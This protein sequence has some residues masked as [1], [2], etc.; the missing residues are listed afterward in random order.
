[1]KEFKHYML[2]EINEQPEVLS[3]ILDSKISLPEEL[4]K[5]CKKIYIVASGTSYHAGLSGKI[6]FERFLG[7]P[8]ETD[9]AS[10]F[11]LR[12]PL[13]DNESL[14]IF[15]SQSGQTADTLASLRYA[16]KIGAKTLALVNVMDSTIANEANFALDIKAGP[17]I[18]IASTKA[19]TA[20]LLIL[21][22][23][24]IEFAEILRKSQSEEGAGL[25]SDLLLLP[26][27]A[28]QI[29]KKQEADF[30]HIMAEDFKK[31]REIFYLGK[32]LD[33]P[34]AREGVL[35]IKEISYIHAE[36]FASGEMKHGTMALIT[37]DSRI[38][39]VNTQGALSERT[40]SIV[41]ELKSMGARAAIIAQEG[42]RA[43]LEKADQVLFIPPMPDLL[44][45][46][47]SIIPL[48]LLAYYTALA[49]GNNVDSPRNLTKAVTSE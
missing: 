40:L 9:L 19:Y 36:A 26:E 42:N 24:A 7:I 25:K 20:T 12:Q 43:S 41:D 3:R 45:P 1:M 10:E 13:I 38:L 49:R 15:I 46:I 32:G 8:V 2:K 33:W 5:D 18:A 47:I 16:N 37:E 14:A 35:K 31:K 17:E 27:Y 28:E 4:I 34:T 11:Y 22:L 39:A 23:L 6:I 48:Q 29:L 21:Y 44:T 30:Y